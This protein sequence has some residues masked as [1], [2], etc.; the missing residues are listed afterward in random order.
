MINSNASLGLQKRNVR[1]R[2][3]RK[4]EDIPVVWLD[5]HL[6]INQLPALFKHEMASLGPGAVRSA[7]RTDEDAV[8]VGQ[9]VVRKLFLEGRK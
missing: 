1:Q 3:Q 8:A 7:Q 6:L 5:G 4:T 9:K 2:R